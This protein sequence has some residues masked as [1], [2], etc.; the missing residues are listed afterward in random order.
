MNVVVSTILS[1]SVIALWILILVCLYGK[2]K[3]RDPSLS[4]RQWLDPLAGTVLQWLPETQ[5][6]KL[7]ESG[8]IALTRQVECDSIGNYYYECFIKDGPV[9][10]D[11]PEYERKES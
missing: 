8:I 11:Y 10:V 5:F 3:R 1:L 2:R 4:E 6:K 7:Y 9:D